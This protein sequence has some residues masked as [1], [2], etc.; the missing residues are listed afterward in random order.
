MC[1]GEQVRKVT[2]HTAGGGGGQVRN[3]A[4]HTC[5]PPS[6]VV[7]PCHIHISIPGFISCHLYSFSTPILLLLHGVFGVEVVASP[8]G[9]PCRKLAFLLLLGILADANIPAIAC[10]P[11]VAGMS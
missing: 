8:P 6:P 5:P 4:L 9:V 2:L 7:L 1:G 11:A 10:F 3:G